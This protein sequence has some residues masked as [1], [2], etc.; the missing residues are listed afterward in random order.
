MR[1]TRV[2]PAFAV[3]DSALGFLGIHVA[4]VTAA[5]PLAV[6]FGQSACRVYQRRPCSHQTSSRP[7]HHQIRLRSGTAMLHRTQQLGIDA[8][9]PSQRPGIQPIVFLRLSPIKRTLR[10]CATIT[11]CPRSLNNRLPQ[12]ECI[13]VSNAMRQRNML[14]NTSRIAF[15]VV[16]TS[17][18]SSTS[19]ASPSRQ[20]QLDRSPRSRPIVSLCSEKFLICFVAAVLI[21]FVAGLLYLLRFKARR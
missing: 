4:H 19:P 12:G 9:Q 3:P 21:F 15:G 20:Y 2:N 6:P 8:R 16:L 17:C 10:A 7:D 11:S 18:S 14:P 13:P 5:Q 1:F